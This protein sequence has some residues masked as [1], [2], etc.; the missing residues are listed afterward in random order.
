MSAHRGRAAWASAHLL[1]D[2]S[3]HHGELLPS[4]GHGKRWGSK[5]LPATPQRGCPQGAQENG[6]ALPRKTRVSYSCRWE[7]VKA[8]GCSLKDC[9]AGTWHPPCHGQVERTPSLEPTPPSAPSQPVQHLLAPFYFTPFLA[10]PAPH[11]V[12]LALIAP[13][14]A[15]FAKA[16]RVKYTDNMTLTGFWLYLCNF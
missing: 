5:S 14:S 8:Q 4:L 2:P 16:V 3:S 10:F 6:R 1:P 15:G 9:L 11:K 7:R 12:I 13:G